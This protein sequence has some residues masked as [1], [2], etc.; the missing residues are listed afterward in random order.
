[1][2]LRIALGATA[3]D[4]LALITRQGLRPVVLG[5]GAG[6]AAALAATRLLQSA[7]FGVT[8]TDP[9]TFGT[10]AGLLLGAA[11]VAAVLP[12]RRASRLDPGLVLTRS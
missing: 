4:V 12:A 8:A 3:R 5:L 1:M 9:I 2:G 6:M 10:V 11:L 7:L